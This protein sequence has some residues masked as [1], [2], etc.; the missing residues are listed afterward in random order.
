MKK[1]LG[2]VFFFLLGILVATGVNIAFAHGGNND[3][4]H[5][6]VKAGSGSL[7]IISAGS[8]CNSNEIPLDWSSEGLD[9]FGGFLSKDLTGYSL[10]YGSLSYRDFDYANFTNSNFSSVGLGFGSFKYANFSNSRWYSTQAPNAD[11]TSANFSNAVIDGI[12]LSNADFTGANLTATDFRVVYGGSSVIQNTNFTNSNFT[13]TN[14][15]GVDFSSTVRT[16]A[17]WNNTICPDG[18]NSDSHGNS[19]EGHLTP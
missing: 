15:A 16:G 18:T 5:G 17:I 10:E 13:N 7:R 4:I 2:Y 8:S 9:T 12:N 19:C 11:F 6:C 1:Y 14:L 3:L